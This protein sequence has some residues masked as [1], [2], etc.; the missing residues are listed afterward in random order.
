[1]ISKHEMTFQAQVLA[2]SIGAALGLGRP[3]RV[4]L[5]F[6]ENEEELLDPLP[7]AAE[8]SESSFRP[9]LILT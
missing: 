6:K 5:H 9:N 7:V 1:M 8:P 4:D 2:R 3:I